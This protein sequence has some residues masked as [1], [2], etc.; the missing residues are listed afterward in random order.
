MD[1]IAPIGWKVKKYFEYFQQK[2]RTGVEPVL[3]YLDVQKLLDTISHFIS[4]KIVANPTSVFNYDVCVIFEGLDLACGVGDSPTTDA[5]PSVFIIVLFGTT[6]M[7]LVIFIC[8]FDIVIRFDQGLKHFSSEF[9][10]NQFPFFGVV[11]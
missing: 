4:Y 5:F 8:S 6:H 2:K 9:F 3:Q 7:E 1:I 10:H 11:G